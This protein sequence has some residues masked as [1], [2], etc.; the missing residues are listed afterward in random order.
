MKL[1]TI[2]AS[3]DPYS[4]GFTLGQATA[5]T[6]HTITVH[7]DEFV[8]TER[9]WQG[10]AYL[11]TMI[12]ASRQVFPEYIRELEG[13]SDGTGISFERAFLWNCRGDLVWGDDISPALAADL[14]EGCT[15]LIIPGTNDGPDI[16]SHNEDGTADFHGSCTW[17]K[18]KPDNGPGFESFLYPGMIPGHTMGFNYAGIVQT[19]NNIRVHDLKP[20]LPRHFIC[21]AILDCTSMDDALALLERSDRASGF[22]HNLGSAKEGRLVSVE[23]PASDCLIKEV[24]GNASAHANHLIS[25]KLKD[26]PQS[27]TTSSTVRQL[28][29]DELLSENTLEE[30]GPTGILF[31]IKPGSEILRSP[32][33][34]GDDYG[35][36]L[37]T[38]VFEMTRE[39]VS[40]SVHDGPEN[41][42]IYQY[43]HRL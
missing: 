6:V 13:M 26:K 35:K 41:L 14:S 15:T 43:S 30:K 11:E 4:I 7:T 1:K 9:K 42:N 29:A 25:E 20:G 39:S 16:I 22:H 33:D 21:R 18:V 12:S 36:T 38:G 34:G 28:R 10:S 24:T 8:E 5:E 3:G 27:I 17:V 31:D 2:T 23:A 37:A 40:V 19:I 32:V